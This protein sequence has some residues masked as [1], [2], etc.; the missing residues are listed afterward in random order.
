MLRAHY[1]PTD[2]FAEYPAL[3]LALDPVLAQ[4]DRLL[5]DDTIIQHVTT[6]LAKR[7]PLTA[8]RGR[9]STPVEVIL[10]QLVVKHLYRWSDEETER[11]VADRLVLRQFCRVYPQRVPDDTTLLRWANLLAPEP[12]GR[13]NDRVVALARSLQVT[14]GRKPRVDSAVVETA[15]HHPT[16]SRRLG[17]GV[18]V[19]GRLLRRAKAVLGEGAALAKDA[20]RSRTRSARQL[21]QQ[22]HRVARRKGKAAAED[23]PQTYGKLI[24]IAQAT[25]RQ[26]QRVKDAL[27][28]QA[29]AHAQHLVD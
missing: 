9:S 27:Q 4:L 16:D 19:L 7:Y 5:D 17:D 29:T 18:R 28:G 11:F 8:R 25:R 15:I 1:P 26:A 21:A 22:L 12:L 6:D 10:R 3:G 2:L 23:L 20:F 24:D 13:L 14:R